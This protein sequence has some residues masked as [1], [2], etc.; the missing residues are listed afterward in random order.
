MLAGEI[1]LFP[2][3]LGEIEELGAFFFSG[4]SGLIAI[5]FAVV[6]EEE[7]PVAFDTP[8]EKEGFFR[9]FDVGNVVGKAF[10]QNVFSVNGC[11]VFQVVQKVQ[12]GDAT[13]WFCTGGG[14]ECWEDVDTGNQFIPFA[15]LEGSWPIEEDGGTNS[16]FVGGLFGSFVIATSIGVLDPAIIG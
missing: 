12:A 3:I 2:G 14:D 13:G 6:G 4:M 5:D 1:L 16:A 15:G 7:F 11:A 10:A 9:I 8:A